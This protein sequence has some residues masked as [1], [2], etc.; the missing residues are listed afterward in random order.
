MQVLPLGELSVPQIASLMAEGRPWLP[1]F[2]DYW[3]FRTF[4]GSTSFFASVGG[5]HAGGLIACLNQDDP[6][7]IYVDQVAV[8]RAFR[9]RGV[10]QAL[11]RA[12]EHR[13]GV[14]KCTR[15]WLST[16]PNNPAVDVWMR[17]GFTNCPGDLVEGRLSIHRDFKGPGKHRAIFEKKL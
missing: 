4:C 3:F 1:E 13:A 2:A 9:G 16:D 17:L 6:K 14:L 10:A 15:V 12:V 8:R 11:V 5:V 7:E